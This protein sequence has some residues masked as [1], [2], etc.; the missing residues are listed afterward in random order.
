[1]FIADAFRGEHLFVEEEIKY[2][3]AMK[4]IADTLKANFLKS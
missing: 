1:M 3:I 4:R 2:M